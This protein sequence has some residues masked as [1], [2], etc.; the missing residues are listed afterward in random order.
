MTLQR[1]TYGTRT[2]MVLRLRKYNII[3]FDL[4]LRETRVLEC[5]HVNLNAVKQNL[6]YL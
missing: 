2:Y 4:S 1:T 6:D 5:I 3:I